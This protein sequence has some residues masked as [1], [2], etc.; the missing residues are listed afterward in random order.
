MRFFIWS[1]LGIYTNNQFEDS[2]RGIKLLNHN[3]KIAITGLSRS[4]KSMFFTSMIHLLKNRDAQ[5]RKDCLPLLT[6]LPLNLLE[7]VDFKMLEGY[8]FFPYEN[9]LD[10]LRQQKWPEP[11][12]DISGFRIDLIMK[13][14]N[15]LVKKIRPTYTISVDFFDYPGE[16]LTDLP[17]LDLTFEQWSNRIRSQEIG[18]GLFHISEQWREYINNFDF[19]RDP[20]EKSIKELVTR[21]KLFLTDAKSKGVTLLQPASILLDEI[22]YDWEQGG[23][24]PLPGDI[25]SDEHHLWTK[26]F[27]ENYQNYLTA[28]LEPQRDKYFK[29]TEAQIIVVDLFEGLNYGKGHLKQLRETITNLSR[30]FVYGRANWFKKHILRQSIVS[31]VA[32]VASKV[33][34][35]P[36]SQKP[37]LLHLLEDVSRGAVSMLRSSGVEYGHFC[38][39]AIRTTAQDD[40]NVDVLYFPNES[41]QIVK[42]TFK[43]SVPGRIFD[44]DDTHNFPS[45]K[46]IP[47]KDW[48][49]QI[50]ESQGIDS[51]MNFMM[52]Q[53]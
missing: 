3:Y 48:E 24:C 44:L 4:G 7:K 23:F 53:Q 41:N 20:N 28:W 38:L 2:F 34:L 21:F 18:D 5:S 40:P 9:N 35:V 8:K 17:M 25:L 27:K 19:D 49:L 30:T 16:W 22:N 52:R 50:F 42:A 32:F 12:K 15:R 11:T 39:S 14:T 10:A 43:S 31:K 1:N 13:Q 33:D 37:K 26:V 36:F 46:T 51:L 29:D 47:N 45:I 6:A